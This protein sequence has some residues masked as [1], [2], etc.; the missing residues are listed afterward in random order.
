MKRIIIIGV[1][2][3]YSHISSAQSSQELVAGNTDTTDL[4][5]KSVTLEDRLNK[6]EVEIQALKKD[7][8]LLKKQMKQVRSSLP[9]TSR[10]L[11]IS[12]TG[13]KQLVTQ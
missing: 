13:S 2:A 5:T 7:N 4:S 6:Q 9:A 10:K 8:S 11:T 1:L 12:R 3:M